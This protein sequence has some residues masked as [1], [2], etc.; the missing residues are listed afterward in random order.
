MLR[1]EL[2]FLDLTPEPPDTTPES[3]APPPQDTVDA[4]ANVSQENKPDS[5]ADE[6]N[7]DSTQPR[8]SE[9]AH[10]LFQ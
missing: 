4:Y 8:R 6:P 10:K 1:R 7:V 3:P 2:P 5:S 9:R